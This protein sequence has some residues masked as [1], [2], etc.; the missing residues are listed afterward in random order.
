MPLH[1]GDAAAG[2]E[3]SH[4]KSVVEPI[5]APRPDR[6]KY[7]GNGCDGNEYLDQSK[8]ICPSRLI[9]HGPIIGGPQ[10]KNY[11]VNERD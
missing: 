1:H 9:V 7:Y 3:Q 6:C 8:L 11:E 10:M 5:D 4:G 2:N